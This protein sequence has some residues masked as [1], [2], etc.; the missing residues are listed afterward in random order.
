ML[1]LNCNLQ[2]RTFLQCV[3][4]SYLSYSSGE[5]GP[6]YKKTLHEKKEKKKQLSS[7]IEIY[8]SL[9]WQRMKY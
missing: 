9:F 1:F 8:K 6:Q 5:I 4:F 2:N 3:R 7:L